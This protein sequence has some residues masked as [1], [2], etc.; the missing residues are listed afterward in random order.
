MEPDSNPWL[1]ERTLTLQLAQ[2]LEHS[3]ASST[4][5]TYTIGFRRFTRFCTH[6]NVNP[7]P[8][9][10]LT[11][12]YFA[13]SLSRSLSPST[14]RVYISAVRA[15]HQQNGL[16]DPTH[17]N[18]QLTLVL[19]GIRR[20]HLPNTSR[21]REPI[22][23]RLLTHMVRH[24][25]HSAALSSLDRQMLAAAFTLAFHGFLRVGEFTMPPHTRFNLR[26]HP[27]TSHV[28]LHR[29]YYTFHIPRSKTDQL[30]HGHTIRLSRTTPATICPVRHMRTYLETRPPTPGALFTFS[31]GRPLTRRLCL[32][33]LRSSL[34]HSGHNPEDYN[35]HS[36]RIGAATT[37]AHEGASE[38]TIQHLGRW[39][40]NAVRAYI[41]PYP[42]CH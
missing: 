3:L 28:E 7:L 10:K 12:T 34:K 33:H 19:R 5:G 4:R 15:A 35:T 31:D 36:F 13:V 26:F 39:R 32:H 30:H 25:R 17:Q 42:S 18:H 6:Y 8:A 24:I 40:S 21:R 22:T 14:I 23:T 9:S 1:A 29:R 37:A 27:S 20:R 11:V 38:S 16:P 41:R 2:L